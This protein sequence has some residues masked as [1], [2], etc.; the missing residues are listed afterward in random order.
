MV[1][2]IKTELLNHFVVFSIHHL[3]YLITSYLDYYHRFRPHQGLGNV[4][5]ENPPESPPYGEIE[6]ISII[7]GLLHH[8]QR[9]AA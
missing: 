2:S 5:I 8:Y 3:E 4:T 7:G 6:K 9:K 1:Q